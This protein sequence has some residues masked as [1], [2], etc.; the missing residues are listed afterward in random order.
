VS[1]G[2][3]LLCKHAALRSH[4]SPTARDISGALDIRSPLLN[5]CDLRLYL[6]G[7]Q[8][9]GGAHAQHVCSLRLYA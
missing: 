3:V 5:R 7:V 2:K 6:P 1:N 9:S 8:L 4:S